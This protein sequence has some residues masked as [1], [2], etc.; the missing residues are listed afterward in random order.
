[1]TIREM[2]YQAANLPREYWDLRP[3]D[4]AVKNGLKNKFVKLVEVCKGVAKRKTNGVVIESRDIILRPEFTA[5]I[6]KYVASWR[7]TQGWWLPFID[8]MQ[9]IRTKKLNFDELDKVMR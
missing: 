3:I 5:V 2:N 8:L 7:K 1:M 6:F 4:Y 9:L